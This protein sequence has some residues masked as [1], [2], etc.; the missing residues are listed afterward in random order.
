MTIGSIAVMQEDEFV[1][2]TKIF[3]LT[4]VGS[5]IIYT[6]GWDNPWVKQTDNYIKQATIAPF[7][8]W[9]LFAIMSIANYHYYHRV[10]KHKEHIVIIIPIVLKKTGDPLWEVKLHSNSY[11]HFTAGHEVKVIST[12][13]HEQVV[14]HH[15]EQKPCYI[16]VYDNEQ[17]KP[18]VVISLAHDLL[19]ILNSTTL[20]LYNQLKKLKKKYRNVNLKRVTLENVI[21]INKTYQSKQGKF[22]ELIYHDYFSQPCNWWGNP[23][24]IY[25]KHNI[26]TSQTNG[27]MDSL[28]REHDHRIS[29][30]NA[31]T[32]LVNLTHYLLWKPKNLHIPSIQ[33]VVTF[34]LGIIE[35]SLNQC[36]KFSKFSMELWNTYSNKEVAA[37]KETD[38]HTSPEKKP[39]KRK[40]KKP[41]KIIPKGFKKN[42]KKNKHKNNQNLSR[43]PNNNSTTLSK[44]DDTTLS[45]RVVQSQ[46]QATNVATPSTIIL[47]KKTAKRLQ[48]LDDTY[49]HAIS[50][51]IELY[52]AFILRETRL[53]SAG[54][55]SL[56]NVN[57]G[58]HQSSESKKPWRTYT[59][60]DHFTAIDIND[61]LADCPTYFKAE[62]DLQ[63][64]QFNMRCYFLYRDC[65]LTHIE[66]SRS[67]TIQIEL[68]IARKEYNTQNN[69]SFPNEMEHESLESCWNKISGKSEIKYYAKVVTKKKKYQ[70]YLKEKK[71]RSKKADLEKTT[72]DYEKPI[73][74]AD[75]LSCTEMTKDN[76]ITVFT[77]MY[78]LTE[79][80]T[81]SLSIVEE[82]M[83]LYYLTDS[84]IIKNNA[85]HLF[86]SHDI[87]A[88]LR[89]YITHYHDHNLQRNERV[90][91]VIYFLD[92]QNAINHDVNLENLIVIESIHNHIEALEQGR[93]NIRSNATNP[94][95]SN[96]IVLSAIRVLQ[97]DLITHVERYKAAQRTQFLDSK[98]HLQLYIMKK[99]LM[100][101]QSLNNYSHVI[102]SVKRKKV[103]T[104]QRNE[105]A[106][107]LFMFAREEDFGN[108][109]I[110]I[111]A[112]EIDNPVMRK[113]VAW[114]KC[115]SEKKDLSI[116]H[117]VF[118]VL[119]QYYSLSAIE[120]STL[121]EHHIFIQC[122]LYE[123]IRT[124]NACFKQ[125]QEVTRL[126]AQQ[127]ECVN[128]ITSNKRLSQQRY[129]IFH[130]AIT[131][132][133]AI[134][135][136]P[137][138]LKKTRQTT[139]FK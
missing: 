122:M 10:K 129:K 77:H 59:P 51:F 95:L 50:K 64:I 83:K 105:F 75:W 20:E 11:H 32:A 53:K 9:T 48:S 103:F 138:N 109:I 102:P 26:E 61:L 56:F 7:Q 41:S 133:S 81:D 33:S 120:N 134:K 63:K 68:Q 37:N 74:I 55:K 82:L 22:Y 67:D 43:T 78:A 76:A 13:Q 12:C 46:T 128:A 124:P 112:W 66:K 52:N 39:K 28:I 79:A 70:P 40:P 6:I 118:E 101:L 107:G 21:D 34:C 35:S 27:I 92:E 15:L 25:A 91:T 17:I 47:R 57:I 2:Y 119:C 117:Q 72:S 45:N 130:S 96:N 125:I 18:S 98:I 114:K 132:N 14:S 30:N 131:L 93:F 100:L 4:R 123:F 135:H 62:N 94:Q 104:R 73:T 85:T 60:E 89:C 136:P 126:T 42:R 24:L 3:I 139:H 31:L 16:I 54:T 86:C 116:L 110:V 71:N 69:S 80:T 137:K 84:S 23:G 19:S 1:K 44:N 121:H 127:N 49:R 8:F 87:L 29:P 5:H 88:H 38:I 36:Y 113:N 97:N 99:T 111:N 65:L 108:L 90:K 58:I 115:L 106:H